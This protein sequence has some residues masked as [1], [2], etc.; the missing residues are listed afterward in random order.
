VWK[1]NWAADLGPYNDVF[2]AQRVFAEEEEAGLFNCTWPKS[3]HLDDGV[4]YRDEVWTGVEYQV[5]SHMVYEGMNTEALAMCRAVHDRYTPA[6]RNPFNEI[7][8]SDFY[9]RAMASWGMLLGLSG[10]NYH[11]PKGH[12]AFAPR[13]SPENFRCV[14]TGAEGWGTFEQKEAG[15]GREWTLAVKHGQVK[16]RTLELAGEGPAT[17][18]V[19][20]QLDGK[21]IEGVSSR[22]EGGKLL[23]QFQPECAIKQNEQ[24]KLVAS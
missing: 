9:A 11:G 1:Y 10:F 20:V 15:A 23:V 3:E 22:L 21:N 24:L 16:L 14:F 18:N 6:R 8:C 7:E 2:P 12:M 17:P 13:M 5:A 19:A 4:L